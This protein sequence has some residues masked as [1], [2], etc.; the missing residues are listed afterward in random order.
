IPSTLKLTSNKSVLGVHCIILTMR[1][2]GLVARGF[3]RI[4]ELTSLIGLLCI[5]CRKRS[6]C[7][8]DSERLQPLEYLRHDRVINT[9]ATERDTA[10]FRQV[11]EWTATVIAVRRGHTYAVIVNSELPS[12][13]PTAQ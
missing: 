2:R 1:S 6:Y 13:S 9:Y 11:G 7:G 10:L 8:L 5:L 3:Q 12:T 4:L